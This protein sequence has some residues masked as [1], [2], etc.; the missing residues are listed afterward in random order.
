MNY[1][2]VYWARTNHLGETTGERIRNSNIR[3]FEKWLDESPFTVR[4]L[5]VERGLYFD[6]IILEN[7]DKEHKKIMFL[8]VANDIPLLIGDIMNWKLDDG[9]VE[10]WLVHQEEKKTNPSYRT[11]WIIRCNYLIKWVDQDG[12][13]QQSWS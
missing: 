13:I 4:N 1:I 12:H 5:S 3:S 6:G 7:K 2:D 8:H 9:T 11:F 10:K